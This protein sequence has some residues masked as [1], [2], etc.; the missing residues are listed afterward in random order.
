MS[1]ARLRDNASKGAGVLPPDGRRIAFYG[2]P[3]DT[4]ELVVIHADGSGRIGRLLPGGGSF[5]QRE[6]LRP[7]L[8]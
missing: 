3:G 6:D 2:D 4:S 8:R 7:S 5:P 1:R